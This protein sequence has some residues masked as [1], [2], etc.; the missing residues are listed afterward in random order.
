MSTTDTN[1]EVGTLE[2]T[3]EDQREAILAELEC[4]VGY[5]NHAYSALEIK[6]KIT[7]LIAKLKELD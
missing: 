6:T 5:I 1:N 3:V 7:T 2:P 4:Y